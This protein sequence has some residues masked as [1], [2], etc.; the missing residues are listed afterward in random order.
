MV[1]NN[2]TEEF[3]VNDGELVGNVC[4]LK[5]HEFKTGTGFNVVGFFGK[6]GANI[7]DRIVFLLAIEMS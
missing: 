5:R 2:L 6:E 1:W 7:A 3:F 4:G